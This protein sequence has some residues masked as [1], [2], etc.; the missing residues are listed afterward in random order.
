[1]WPR[2]S[3]AFAKLDKFA[4]VPKATRGDD[5]TLESLG[6]WQPF[7][8]LEAKSLSLNLSVDR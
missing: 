7:F 2:A 1:M 4:P 6:N 8:R 3:I 5:T